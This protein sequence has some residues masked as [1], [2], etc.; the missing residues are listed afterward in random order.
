[1]RFLMTPRINRGAAVCVLALCLGGCSGSD[2]NR[3]LY[4]LGDQYACTR[5]N[6]ERPDATARNVACTDPGH[7]RRTSYEDYE[8]ARDSATAATE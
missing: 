2:L 7:P 5:G 8:R 4:V 6:D 1:M 3:W